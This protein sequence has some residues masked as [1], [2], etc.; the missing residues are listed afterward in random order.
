MGRFDRYVGMY[1]GKYLADGWNVDIISDENIRR[2]LQ[3][4]YGK[5]PPPTVYQKI[6]E[7]VREKMKCPD[8]S[9]RYRENIKENGMRDRECD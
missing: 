7:A 9:A 3:H 4:I 2:S 6:C 1:A 5:K 8:V